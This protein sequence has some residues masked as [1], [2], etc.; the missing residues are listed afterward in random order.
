MRNRRRSTR[1]AQRIRDEASRP[2]PASAK[3]R[4]DADPKSHGT[5]WLA[6]A[7][8]VVGLVTG[9]FTLK[10][11]VFD[12]GSP[13]GR[14]VSDD[15]SGMVADCREDVGVICDDLTKFQRAHPST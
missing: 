11:E 7:A 5:A 6:T 10:S 1:G 15:V 2:P 12:A 9:V 3:D 14:S 4:P 8:T 13:G